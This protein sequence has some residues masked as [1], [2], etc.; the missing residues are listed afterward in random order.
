MFE[1]DKAPL[2]NGKIEVLSGFAFPSSGF[3]QLDGLPLIRIRDLGG[4]TTE[5]RFRGA[6][7]PAYRVSKGD[8]LVAMD[9]DF[10]VHR[11]EGEDALLNQRVCRISS[12]S[13]EIDQGFLYWYLKPKIAEIHR[14]TPQTTVR[15]LSTKDVYA[16]AEPPIGYPAQKRIAQILD[17]LDTAIRETQELIVK[18]KAVKQG[19]LHDLLTRGIDANGQLRPRQSEAPQLYKESPLGWIPSKW[20]V[21][22]LDTVTAR[23]SGHTP[24]KDVLSYWNGG[25]KW[26][27]LADSHRLD[28]IYIHET[29]KEISELGIA[30]SS[31]VLHSEGT[32]ILSRDAG[33]GKSAILGC[34]MA[35]SQHFM[36][37]RCGEKL[38]NL[39]LYF[40]LQREKPKFEAI[41]MGSTIKTIGLPFFKGYEIALPPRREQDQAAAIMMETE[42][43]LTAHDAELEKLR[44]QKIGLMDDLLTGRVRV[45]PL[46]ESMQQA[47]AQTEA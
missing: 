35:V 4:S 30:N 47:A 22:R 9:G 45:T 16:I 7:D 41:A 15:H 25:V 44:Q 24:S 17:T 34:N 11:W 32:V 12:A 39:F 36:A 33:I 1:L 43:H 29:D 37:W 13:R 46:L 14:R 40:Y 42:Q 31:A 27:S 5:V 6:Y 26:V 2:L 10:E 38:N 23:G 28:Q 19:L 3:N 18:L 21:L 20:E 8:L